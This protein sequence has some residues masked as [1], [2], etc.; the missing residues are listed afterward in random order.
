MTDPPH[1]DPPHTDPL[2]DD[3]PRRVGPFRLK[4]RLGAGGMGQV[5]FGRSAGGRPVA[6]K[7]VPTLPD[8]PEL[9]RR[10]AIEVEAA[11]T[12][13]GFYTAQV[14]DADPDGDPPWLA[15]AYVAG[16]SL[17]QTVVEHGPLPVDAVTMMGAGLAEALHAVH[18]QGLV[19]RDLKPGNVILAEDGPRLIDFGIARAMEATTSYTRARTVLGTA[20]Y[21]SPEQATGG[22]VGPATDIFS[23][24]CVLA[25]AASGRSPFGAGT[26]EAVA[27]RI[28][29]EEPDLTGIPPRLVRV[30]TSCLEKKPPK[31][32]TPDQLVERLARLAP[33]PDGGEARR[34]PTIVSR[35]ARRVAGLVPQQLTAAL[36]ASELPAPP[37]AQRTPPTTASRTASTTGR[38]SKRPLELRAW[39]AYASVLTLLSLACFALI[40]LWFQTPFETIHA[41]LRSGDPTAR[42]RWWIVLMSGATLCCALLSAAQLNRFARRAV[43]K[44]GATVLGVLSVGSALVGLLAPPLAFY[45]MV[46]LLHTIAGAGTTW[47]LSCTGVFLVLVLSTGWYFEGDAWYVRGRDGGW[48]RKQQPGD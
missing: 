10:F 5:F 30:I 23:L 31:R 47:W 43:D 46:H 15:T 37:R 20:A 35:T 2:Q 29:H 14:V 18:A 42:D 28:V 40:G 25:Y 34:I 4:G 32:P 16:P 39:Q 33:D 13:G 38:K 24:G 8:N 48:S 22:T 17:E 1:N 45:G 27:Y 7:L 26:P 21:M 44:V 6:V 11:R 9:R 12:V 36:S 19:H 41:I 3:D